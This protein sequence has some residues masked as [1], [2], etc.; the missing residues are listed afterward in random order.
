[1][2]DDEA[3]KW[4]EENIDEAVKGIDSFAEDLLSGKLKWKCPDCG[5]EIPYLRLWEDHKERLNKGN[6]SSPRFVPCKGSGCHIPGVA[7][8]FYKLNEEKLR[9]AILGILD[10]IHN[11]FPDHVNDWLKEKID[12]VLENEKKVVRAVCLNLLRE[13]MYGEKLQDVVIFHLENFTN[14]LKGELSGYKDKEKKE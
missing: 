10:H 11:M 4:L 5:G 2:E 13:P 7:G 14:N 6:S 3:L 9:E 8:K 12:T 1:M